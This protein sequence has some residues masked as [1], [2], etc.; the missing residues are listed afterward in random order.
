MTEAQA[1]W[2]KTIAMA[3]GLPRNVAMPPHVLQRG[4]DDED[5]DDEDDADP[6][7]VAEHTRAGGIETALTMVAPYIPELMDSWRGKKTAANTGQG[8][9]NPMAHLSR[10]QAQLTPSERQ[11]LDIVLR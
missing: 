9:T 5:D 1:D 10:I 4:A 11:L 3:K 8:S 7:P 6:G 2:V